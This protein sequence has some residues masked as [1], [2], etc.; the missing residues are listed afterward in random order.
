[1]TSTNQQPTGVDPYTYTNELERNYVKEAVED[2]NENSPTE[3]PE[4]EDTEDDTK[5]HNTSDEDTKQ[6]A[7]IE[8]EGDTLQERVTI[9]NINIVTEMYTSQMTIQQHEE[10]IHRK[11]PRHNYNLRKHPSKQKELISQW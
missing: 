5:T 9:Y 1:M 2:M 8:H 3:K 11:I 4:D 10:N 7:I 6:E